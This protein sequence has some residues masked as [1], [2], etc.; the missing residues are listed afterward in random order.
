MEPA[1]FTCFRYMILV[2]VF[3]YHMT[4]VYFDCT[5]SSPHT[6][7]RVQSGQAH[8]PRALA[9]HHLAVLAEHVRGGNKD[10]STPHK[11]PAKGRQSAQ[12]LPQQNVAAQKPM[13]SERDGVSDESRARERACGA[14]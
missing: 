10:R 8:L 13:Q 14:G 6:K 5:A 7:G 12:P 9:A 1:K 11:K 2:I 4:T 3:E